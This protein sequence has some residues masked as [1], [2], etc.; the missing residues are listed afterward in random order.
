M[1]S[2]REV[3]NFFETYYT[4]SKGETLNS[5]IQALYSKSRINH[6]RLMTGFGNKSVLGVQ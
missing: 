4:Y 5:I 2:L 3:L 1:N 6:V